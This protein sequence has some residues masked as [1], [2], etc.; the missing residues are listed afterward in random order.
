MNFL[1]NA[2]DCNIEKLLDLS[3]ALR[4]MIEINLDLN[5]SKIID[6]VSQEKLGSWDIHNIFLY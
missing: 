2:D 5:K 6:D 4:E 3:V 1:K